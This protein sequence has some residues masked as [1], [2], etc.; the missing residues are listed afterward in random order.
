[1]VLILASNGM[2]IGALP[3]I[4]IGAI[5]KM[6]VKGYTDHLHKLTVYD[7]EPE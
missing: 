2:R 3:D 4:T 7:G 1:M 5:S 6:N